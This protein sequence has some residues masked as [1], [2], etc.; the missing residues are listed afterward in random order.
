[1]GPSSVCGAV[2]VPVAARRRLGVGALAMPT[3]FLQVARRRPL[4]LMGSALAYIWRVDE[5]EAACIRSTAQRGRAETHPLCACLRLASHAS[6]LRLL[7][8]ILVHLLGLELGEP[9]LGEGQG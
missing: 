6:P 5:R 9:L 1:M 2:P 8:A 7:L 4:L 3:G